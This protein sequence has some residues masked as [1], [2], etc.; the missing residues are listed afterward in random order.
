MRHAGKLRNIALALAAAGTLMLAAVATAWSAEGD[1]IGPLEAKR[2]ITQAK[3]QGRIVTTFRCRPAQ[4]LKMLRSMEVRIVTAPNPQKRE[5]ETYIN[6]GPLNFR[7]GPPS[8]W[9]QWRRVSQDDVPGT[10][11]MTRCV[12]FHKK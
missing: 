3:A 5:W 10:G 4:K 8:E 12:L 11:T 7:P 2:A 1:W 6:R 9:N